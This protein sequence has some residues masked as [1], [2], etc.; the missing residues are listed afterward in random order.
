MTC[1]NKTYEIKF[2]NSNA[3][4]LLLISVFAQTDFPYLVFYFNFCNH[5]HHFLFE[6]LT[7]E[8]GCSRHYACYKLAV[9]Q[10]VLSSSR[11]DTILTKLYCQLIKIGHIF[12][13]CRGIHQ[14]WRH[15]KDRFVPT[16]RSH[17]TRNTT[18]WWFTVLL[19]LLIN[20]RVTQRTAHYLIVTLCLPCPV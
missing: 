1:I 10:L 11:I 12:V 20:V 15:R 18:T 9:C 14:E 5:L 16:L 2:P 17:E 13:E 3:A 19:F 7:S 4:I 6:F 8:Y